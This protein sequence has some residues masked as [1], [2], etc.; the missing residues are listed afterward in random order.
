MDLELLYVHIQREKELWPF[1]RAQVI[2]GLG[3]HGSN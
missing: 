3:R 2:T 1:S